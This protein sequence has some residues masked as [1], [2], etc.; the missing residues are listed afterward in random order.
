[1][2]PPRV[3]APTR[4]TLLLLA[5]L[6]PAHA[7]P[8]FS[9]GVTAVVQTSSDSR[10]SDAATASADLVAAQLL[11]FGVL[12][13]Y[14]EG[15][16]TVRPDSVAGR[17]PESNG[18]A[19]SALDAGGR[20]RLQ[21]SELKL[22]APAAG[23]TLTGGLLDPPS[24]LDQSRIASDENTQFLAATFVQNPTIAFPDYTLGLVYERSPDTGLAWSALLS[25]AMGLADTPGRAYEE[26]VRVT[27]DE[28]GAFAALGTGWRAAAGRLRAGAWINTAPH[29][30]LAGAGS[31]DNYGAYLLAGL[32]S[33]P[34]A[35]SLRAG[36]ANARVAAAW[37]YLAAAWQRQWPGTV[38]GLGVAGIFAS[39]DAP[40]PAADSANAELYLRWRAATGVFVTP[41]LQYFHNPALDG[42]GTTADRDLATAN[43]RLSWVW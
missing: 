12:T 41:S 24:Y 11:A 25:S 20:G 16:T 4:S 28:R 13:L 6:A 1:M 15:S 27:D 36:V 14:V 35:L 7:A 22:A 9:G 38:L 29:A 21:V 10:L 5:A 23:G 31:E 39:P 30:R 19:G 42:S 18:D 32:Q 17:V 26:L 8:E 33:G 3:R 43:L 40:A 34:N 2:A 37:A